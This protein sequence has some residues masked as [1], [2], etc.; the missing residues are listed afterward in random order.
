M[1]EHRDL[2]PRL[3]LRQ[4]SPHPTGGQ[5]EAA[6]GTG[7][8]D[9]DPGGDDPH[10]QITRLCLLGFGRPPTAAQRAAMYATYQRLEESWVSEQKGDESASRRALENLCHA[11]VNSA[12]F[13][14][15]D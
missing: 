11:V 5:D 4:G 7:P 12:A 8:A 2:L 15:L 3:Q 6:Q 9:V 10:Q 1:D 13:L 14:Y